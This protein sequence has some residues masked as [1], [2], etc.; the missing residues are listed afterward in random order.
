MNSLAFVAGATGYTGA[1]L[2]ARLRQQGTPTIAHVRPDSPELDAW[3]T[4]FE[5]LGAEIDT[6]PW[7]LDALTA[8]LSSARP[9]VVFALLGTTRRRAARDPDS[10][11]ERVDYGLTRLL[12]DACVAAGCA[13]RFVY[14]SSIGVGPSA[15]GAYL[16]VRHRMETELRASGLPWIIA[17]P[18]FITGPDRAERRVGERL[19]A[20]MSQAFFTLTDALGANFD[21][22]YGAM[23]ADQLAQAL[24]TAGFDNRTPGR[25]LTRFDLAQQE[26][27]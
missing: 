19:G 26:V 3:R 12:M 9:A 6:T 17:R 22:R 20:I 5:A 18:A 7:A 16:Q 24:V 2:V 21:A 11:Y 23:T 13:P 15:R 27:Q 10:T 1:A 8:R 25:V 4:R 14:L